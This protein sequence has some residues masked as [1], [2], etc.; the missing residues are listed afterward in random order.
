M[1]PANPAKVRERILWYADQPKPTTFK[2]G[3]AKAALG[4][5]G[6]ACYEKDGKK[7]RAGLNRYL[8]FA[9]VLTPDDEYFRP[10][11]SKAILSEELGVIWPQAWNALDKWVGAIYIEGTGKWHPRAEFKAECGMVLTFAKWAYWQVLKAQFNGQSEPLMIDLV[12]SWDGYVQEVELEKAGMVPEAIKYLGAIVT[13][14]GPEASPRARGYDPG[15]PPWMEP[16]K[17]AIIEKL[18]ERHEAILAN[19]EPEPRK[20]RRIRRITEEELLIENA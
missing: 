5:I 19:A 8:V 3:R 15:P 4:Q 13:G 14:R 18:E 17:V 11:S 1:K 9:A 7:N 20:R 10:V 6:R 2:E 16:E 12:E